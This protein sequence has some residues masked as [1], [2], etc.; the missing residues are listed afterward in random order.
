VCSLP[1][2]LSLDPVTPKHG[3]PDPRPHVL[4]L[5]ALYAGHRTRFMNL[6]DHTAEDPR[7]RAEYRTVSGWVEGGAV[8]RLRFLPAGTRGRL[9][10]V[11]E[12]APFAR[13][14]RPDVIWTSAGEL[15]APYAWA[16]LGPLRRP[17][18]LDVDAS[19][20][21]LEENA[22]LYWGRPSPPRLR[23]A[24]AHR[25]QQ[26]VLSMVSRF[27]V[28]SEWAAAGLERLGPSRDLMRVIPP[29]VDLTRWRPSPHPP[30]RPIR[31]LFVGADFERKGGPMLLDVLRSRSDEFELDVVTRSQVPST[32]WCRVHRAEANSPLLRRLYAEADLFIL[33]TRAECFGIAAIEAMAS[34]LPVIMS[35]VGAA[36]EIVEDGETGFVIQ[37]QPEDL[38]RVLDAV[39]AQPER[40]GILGRRG[41]QLA[42]E[43]FD[44]Q[45]N[46]SMLI[47]LLLEEY[48]RFRAH[49]AAAMPAA[50]RGR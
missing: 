47:D 35:D 26:L 15:L 6:R 43:R 44:G 12:A 46:D 10:A 1:S 19:P 40:L 34:G 18:V 42:E 48:Q 32:P 16:Q 25:R 13:L 4:F 29:G 33:P 22:E 20:V 37:P 14:P 23:L 45:R 27:A 2:A 38:A 30:G 24:L 8:E 17:L 31:L 49:P 41:R 36:R 3:G 28:W 5:G 21:Q 11:A 9:R 7:I 39:V 50:A